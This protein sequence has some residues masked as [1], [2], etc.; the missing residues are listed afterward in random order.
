[1]GAH[2]AAIDAAFAHRGITGGPPSAPTIRGPQFVWQGEPAVFHLKAECGFGPLR[3]SWQWRPDIGAAWVQLPD[4]AA[5]V[6][7]VPTS[8]WMELHAIVTDQRGAQVT[9][10]AQFTTGSSS[11]HVRGIHIVGPSILT[12]GLRTTYGCTFDGGTGVPP[13]RIHWSVSGAT[14]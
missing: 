3:Y 5:R 12:P 9:A 13:V 8:V 4:V 10:D 7:V 11:Q 2:I 1:G 14:P 6:T